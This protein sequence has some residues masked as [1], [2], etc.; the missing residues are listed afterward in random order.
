M[1]LP[2]FLSIYSLMASTIH[3]ILCFTSLSLCSLLPLALSLPSLPPPL[4][5]I[6][7]LPFLFFSILYSF[8]FFSFLLSSFHYLSLFPPPSNRILSIFTPQPLCL[9]LLPCNTS[10]FCLSTISP[11][12]PP[13]LVT[14]LRELSKNQYFL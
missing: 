4:L 12:S 7:K 6:L 2:L 9:I 5:S 13:L 1:P 10:P 14:A 11:S 8:L 3:S